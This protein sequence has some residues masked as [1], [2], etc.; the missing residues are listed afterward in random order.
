MPRRSPRDQAVRD[1]A[2]SQAGLLTAAQLAEIG[3]HSSTVSR[4]E[5][6]GM[7]T[8][9]L[10]GVHLVGG[11]LP[12]RHQRIMATQLYAGEG[13]GVTGTAGLR[14]YGFR[15]L[16]LQD[17][18]DDEPERPEPVHVLVPHERRR[19]STGFARIERTRRMPELVRVRGYWAAPVARAVGDAA[20][21]LPSRRDVL[22]L[23]AEAIQRGFATWE[24][25]RDE[26]EAGPVRGSAFLRAG[27]DDLRSGAHSPPEADLAGLLSKARIPA[28]HFNVRLVTESG[29]FV[30]VPDVWLDDVGLPIEVDSVEHHATGAGFERTVRRNARYAA[31]GLTPVTVLPVDLRTRPAWVLSQIVA[32]RE[33]AAARPRPPVRIVVDGERAPGT[34]AWPWGA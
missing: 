19:L 24:E 29:R 22:A 14:L 2:D 34:A 9:V 17:P 11:G 5:A 33:A 23:A 4:R 26:L 31:V 16:G 7:W 18:R 8:R 30:S 32:A 21:R 28:A 6:G 27:L 10:P 20:R 1:T 25:L 13:S 3:V 12:T 15:S